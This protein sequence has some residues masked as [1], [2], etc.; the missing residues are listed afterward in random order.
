MFTVESNPAK[1]Q[2]TQVC[3]FTAEDVF[4]YSLDLAESVENPDMRQHV[5]ACSK[6]KNILDGFLHAAATA[7]RLNSPPKNEPNQAVPNAIGDF[8]ILGVIAEGGMGKVFKAYDPTLDRL[9]ALKVMK[10]ELSSNTKFCERFVS[11]AKTLA[12]LNHPNIVLV[13]TVGRHEGQLFIAM[14]LIEGQPLTEKIRNRVLGMEECIATFLQVL[15]GVKVAHENHIIHRDIKPANIMVANM[16]LVKILDFG[17]AKELLMDSTVTH[18]AEGAVLGTL[19][20]LAPEIV[21]GKKATIQSDIYALGLVLYQMLTNRIPFV[22][23]S[24]VFELI[25]RIK[26]EALIPPTALNSRV[27]RNIEQLILKMCAKN[28]EDRYPSVEAVL[29]ELA[30][31]VSVRPKSAAKSNAALLASDAKKGSAFGISAAARAATLGSNRPSER[32]LAHGNRS[33]RRGE[34][35]AVSTPATPAAVAAIVAAGVLVLVLALGEGGKQK[36][37]PSPRPTST[38][39]MPKSSAET[40]VTQAPRP[41]ISMTAAPNP[42]PQTMTKADVD[43]LPPQPSTAIQATEPAGKPVAP[44]MATDTQV[45]A[46]NEDT[47][48]LKQFAEIL[49]QL[50]PLLRTSQFSD[51]EKLLNEKISDPSL[52]G[53]SERLK[54]ELMDLA[55]VRALRQRALDALRAK[56]G[57]AVTLSMHGMK[58]TGTVKGGSNCAGLALALSD[59]PELTIGAEQLD[60]R[61]A[62]AYAPVEM[63]SAKAGDLR[64]RGLL[65]LAAGDTSKAEAYIGQA[66][67]AGLGIA[68]KPY[69]ERIAALK[70][71]DKEASANEAWKKAEGM[72]VARNWESARQAYE[73]FQRD[74]AGSVVQANNA[75][76]LKKHLETIGEALAPPREISLDLG[77]G[78]KLQLILIPVGEFEMGAND[79]EADQRPVHKLKISRPFYMGKY[80]V[81]QE[82]YEKVM[83]TNPSNFKGNNNLPVDDVS[84]L[85]AEEFCT[86]ASK[87]AARSI[88]LPTEAEWEYACRAGTKTRFNTGDD[89][90]AL[91]KEGWFRGNAEARTHPVG[92][93]MPNGWGLYDMHGNVWEWCQD[94]YRED[95][96]SKCPTEN[97]SGP[98]QGSDGVVR[99]GAFN[100]IPWDCRSPARHG[101][102][103]VAH[104]ISFGFRVAAPAFR[105][106]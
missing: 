70:L 69:L 37:G 79:G 55:E 51:V 24:A 95:Y 99:G 7:K 3:R 21:M 57:L 39:A 12:K 104:F 20:Y 76:V 22:E 63:G 56:S 71:G 78:I 98:E 97:P 74:Y 82:Q 106:P 27:P 66:R 35:Q 101:S 48:S 100:A 83:G 50:T 86:R 45:S 68:V 54:K 77:G 59:G 10:D 84:R 88:R 17:L 105:T 28:P 62:D 31:P 64:R 13:D 32:V 91:D 16:G 30:N 75:E 87:I 5:Q 44:A 14:E 36:A 46:K 6:C 29:L 26:T 18:T 33:S 102:P 89:D 8:K 80:A 93:K 90:A 52:A 72:F 53:I 65:F 2:K 11:E 43:K 40:L 73:A 60:A 9:L 103:V 85:D 58:I 1:A 42:E 61:D 47:G 41:P 94:W 49:K 67:D 19:A 4:S 38:E 23:T 25:E 15:E 96:Y 81:T 34:R 92:Q